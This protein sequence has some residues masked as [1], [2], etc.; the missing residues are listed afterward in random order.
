[1]FTYDNLFIFKQY[2]D[3]LYMKELQEILPHSIKCMLQKNF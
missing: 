1:M 3:K 2:Y